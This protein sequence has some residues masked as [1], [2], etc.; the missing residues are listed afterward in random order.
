MKRFVFIWLFP[1]IVLL[2]PHTLLSQQHTI[3]ADLDTSNP[4]KWQDRSILPTAY[5][6]MSLDIQALTTL[7]AQAPM[8]RTSASPL[9][10]SLPMPDGSMQAFAIS[11]SPI[12]EAGLAA[13][14][15]SIRNYAGKGIDD[16]TATM[17]ISLTPKG[18]RCLILSSN[19]NTLI[20]PASRQMA[21]PYLSYHVS[22]LPRNPNFQGICGTIE[23]EIPL[24]PSQRGVPQA[25]GQELLTY[26]LAV[27]SSST[28][29]QWAG[30]TVADAISEI[31]IA[32][33][34]INTVLERDA[35][36]HLA[37]VAN[38]DLLVFLPSQTDP[39]TH[40]SDECWG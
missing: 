7:L 24:N 4:D 19:G 15:P 3:W 31:N 8:E 21:Q 35:S 36:I 20:E 29:T 28:Y 5:R 1:V 12:M 27:S 30:G 2:V 14:F 16:P 11:E 37:L 10:L 6:S 23:E 22:E 34:Q 26:R 13:K 40:Q 33:S 39:F 38:N 9:E 17:R 18:F 32:V 25:I